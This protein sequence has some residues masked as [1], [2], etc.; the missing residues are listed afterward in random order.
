LLRVHIIQRLANQ[1]LLQ[2]GNLEL[3]DNDGT[4]SRFSYEPTFGRLVIFVTSNVSYH[5][6][7]TPLACPPDVTRKSIALYY[8]TVATPEETR[9]YQMNCLLAA[10]N[11]IDLDGVVT[12]S[13]L[14][15]CT[16]GQTDFVH[17]RGRE[18]ASPVFETE[19]N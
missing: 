5:G 2:G 9:E 19:V 7:P 15:S 8:Y 11:A 4:T 10:G 12:D 13:L 18:F 16:F 3:F 6:H 1:R 17:H 14:R